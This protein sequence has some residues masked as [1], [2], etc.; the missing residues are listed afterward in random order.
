M[1]GPVLVVD[2]D[3]AIREFLAL[4]LADAGYAVATAA[5]GAEAVAKAADAAP[6]MVLLDLQMPVMTGQ[7]ALAA[8]R[9]LPARIPVVFMTAGLRSQAEAERHGADGY[10]VKP[11][12]LDQL[13]DL[14]ARFAA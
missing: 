14:V 9:R 3:D 12:D 11:F 2:D 7:E 5:D 10:L 8:L 6:A 13:L 4:A 1:S